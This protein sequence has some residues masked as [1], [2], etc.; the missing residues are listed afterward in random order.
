MLHSCSPPPTGWTCI[1]RPLGLIGGAQ[2]KPRKCVGCNSR[3]TRKEPEVHVCDFAQKGFPA[4]SKKTGKAQPCGVQYHA[5]CIKVGAPFTSRL[6]KGEC[7]FS[8]WH[9]PMPHYICELCLVRAH[10]DHELF[11]QGI[12]LALLMVER[13]QQID[14]VSGWSLNTLKKYGLYLK[15]LHRFEDRF[16][17]QLF[18]AKPLLRPPIPP[19]IHSIG[20]SN[21]MLSALLTGEAGNSIA[22]N[23]RLFDK[24]AVRRLGTTLKNCPLATPAKSC[25]IVF[26]V[27]WPCPSYHLQMMLS[28]PSLLLE[29]LGA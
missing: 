7:L 9:A 14:Y 13:V 6:A 29:W 28:L 11:W 20:R 4:W 10:L 26:D 1:P 22:S 16:G 5:R 18:E 25:E 24:F 19:C 2:T 23:S 8:P 27:A 15:Y 12:D 21:Y 3:F 17:V